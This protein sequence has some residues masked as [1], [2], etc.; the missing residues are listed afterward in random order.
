MG[1]QSVVASKTN[2][3]L[4]DLQKPLSVVLQNAVSDKMALSFGPGGYDERPM[5][6]KLPAVVTSEMRSDAD[7]ASRVLW[8]ALRPA[9]M[10]DAELWLASLGSLT[11]SRKD[12]DDAEAAIRAM[13]GLLDDVPVAVLTQEVLRKAAK[14]FKWWPSFAELAEFLDTE[15]A[16][17]ERRLKRLR[18]IAEAPE[19]SSAPRLEHHENR[20]RDAASQERGLRAIAEIKTALRA[21]VGDQA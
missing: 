20:S 12:A 10:A 4:V 17:L 19:T 8:R 16:E 7:A 2:N 14:K 11:I 21:A 18:S 5:P 9:S 6:W 13:A 3:P 1:H 15:K